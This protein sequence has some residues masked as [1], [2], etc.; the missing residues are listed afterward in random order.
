GFSH[1]RYANPDAPRSGRLV[2]GVLGSFDSLN[3][4]IIRGLPPQ[5]LRA[6]LVSGAN[7]IAGHVVESLMVR[8]YDEPFTLYG[9]I[10]ESV[11]TDAARSFVTFT[12]NPA[13]RFSDGKPVTPEDVVFSWQLLRDRGRPNH[14][15]FY[16]KVVKAEISGRSVRFDLGANEDRELPLILGL[17]P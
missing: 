9:L 11:E 13:A 6:P 3:P 7:V 2:Q 1:F 14:R 4:F 8:G 15:I 12:L 5:G 10:A 17:M 16:S